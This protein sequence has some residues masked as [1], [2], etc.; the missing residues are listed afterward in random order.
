MILHLHTIQHLWSALQQLCLSRLYVMAFKDLFVSQV[1]KT[2]VLPMRSSK[3]PK[4]AFNRD[5]RFT[6]LLCKSS[7]HPS[8]KELQ[9][10]SVSQLGASMRIGSRISVKLREVESQF[11]QFLDSHANFQVL[12]IA[13]FFC[14][15][16]FG[17]HN[18]CLT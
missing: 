10:S 5:L 1:P 3:D 2:K 4:R 14:I 9:F 11:K 13:C 16:A 17:R 8:K 7:L 18:L 15:D 6:P 12:G